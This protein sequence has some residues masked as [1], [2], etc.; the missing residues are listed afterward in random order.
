MAN[1]S[2]VVLHSHQNMNFNTVQQTSLLYYGAI[3]QSH[4]LTELDLWPNAL[5]AVSPDG[6]IAWI[7]TDV[8]SADVQQVASAHNWDLTDSTIRFIEGKPGEWLL[9]GLVDTHSDSVA[10][11]VHSDVMTDRFSS[12]PHSSLT[13]ER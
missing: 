9:P 4:S 1:S 11:S 13:S 7:E 6:V 5:L 10:E 2:L 8:K 12:M 3:V